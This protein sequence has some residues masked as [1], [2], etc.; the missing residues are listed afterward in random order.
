MNTVIRITGTCLRLLIRTYQ[1]LISPAL[2]PTCR[3]APSCSAYAI[4]AVRRLGPTRGGWLA[5]K[6]LV[7]CH[8]WGGHGLDP[9]PER[10]QPVGVEGRR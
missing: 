5:L 2:P 7:R 8:P 10:A 9:V 6:R 4:E 1:L 3:F